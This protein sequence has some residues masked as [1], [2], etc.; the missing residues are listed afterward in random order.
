MT[1]LAKDIGNLEYSQLA[2]ISEA[3][4]IDLDDLLK[5]VTQNADGTFDASNLLDTLDFDKS[6]QEYINSI[7]AYND[8]VIAKQNEVTDN[9]KDEIQNIGNAKPG[10]SVNLTQL[11][12]EF[13][14]KTLNAINKKLK[15]YSASIEDGILKTS[16]NTNMASVISVLKDAGNFGEEIGQILRD[17][18]NEIIANYTDTINKGIKGSLTNV[19]AVNLQNFASNYGLQI[20]FHQTE[21][22][23]KLSQQSAMALYTTMKQVDYLQSR[24]VFKELSDNLKESTRSYQDVVAIQGRIADLQ[25][26]INSLP[27]GS[28]RRKEYERELEVAK[29]IREV[30]SLTDENA[31]NFM[32]ND[33]PTPFK[34]QLGY[35]DSIG[36]AFKEMNDAADSGYMDVTKFYN[37]V[38]GFN[39]MAKQMGTSINFMGME[40]DGSM[41]SASKA[42][43]KGFSSLANVDGEG[44]KVSLERWGNSFE[45]GAK[46]MQKGVQAG[47][48]AIA[49][50]QIEMLDAMIA[51]LELVVAME[52]LE[53]V[54]KN[55][56]NEISFEE[57]WPHFV[58]GEANQLSKE[59]KISLQNILDLA[60]KNKDLA[61]AL[62]TFQIEG[63]SM[64]YWMQQAIDGNIKNKDTAQ[65]FQ[66]TLSALY[67]ALQTG[68][69]S[70]ETIK[71]TIIQ[72]LQANIKEGEWREFTLTDGTKV[73]ISQKGYIEQ[74]KKGKWRVSGDGKE[75]DSFE[76][77]QNAAEKLTEFAEKT[78]I[79]DGH[80]NEAGLAEKSYKISE[81]T[82][83]TVTQNVNGEIEY[84][85]SKTGT[86]TTKAKTLRGAVR[87]IISR[88][89]GKDHLNADH[90]VQEADIL[91]LDLVSKLGLTVNDVEILT[92]QNVGNLSDKMLTALGIDTSLV[93][94]IEAGIERAL[95][96]INLGELILNGLLGESKDVDQMAIKSEADAEAVKKKLENN[97]KLKT[98]GYQ[99]ASGA[100]LAIKDGITENKELNIADIILDGL[101][102]PATVSEDGTS[103]WQTNDKVVELGR[104]LGIGIFQAIPGGVQAGNE[105]NP[106][107]IPDAVAAGAQDSNGIVGEAGQKLADFIKTP[108]QALGVNGTDS[109]T[110]AGMDAAQAFVDGFT[111]MYGQGDNRTSVFGEVF[112]A[113]IMDALRQALI[114]DETRAIGQETVGTLIE[115]MTASDG[116]SSS[117]VQQLADSITGPIKT[118]LT[119]LFS[120]TTLDDLIDL[121]KTNSDLVLAFDSIDIS[122]LTETV[123]TFET[124]MATANTALSGII[125]TINGL[126][127]TGPLYAAAFTL[128]VNNVSDKTPGYAAD[129][130]TA[131]NAVDQEKV[132]QSQNF[133]N[134]VN[135]VETE[136][137]DLSKAFVAAIASIEKEQITRAE[138][139]SAAINAI[140]ETGKKYAVEFAGAMN[141]ITSNG[142]DKI[143]DFKSAI[144]DFG[145]INAKASVEINVWGTGWVLNSSWDR[146]LA[147]GNIALGKGSLNNAPA[148]SKGRKTLMGELGPELYV[149]NGRYYVAGQNGAEMVD[150]PDDAIVFNHL[151]TKR[152]LGTG[153]AGRGKP[154][155]NEKRAI[156][157][158]TGNASGP[159]MA[160]ARE[161]LEQLKAL[162][163]MFRSMLTASFKQL[164]GLAASN[165]NKGGT[166]DKAVKTKDENGNETTT[167]I[168]ISRVTDDINRWYNLMR[169]IDKLEKD[170]SYSEQ[171]INKYQSDRV[172]NGNKIYQNYKNQLKMLDSEISK[173]KELVQIQRDWY[174]NKREEIAN[175]SYGLIFQYDENGLLQFVEGENRG[176][177]LLEKLNEETI[178]GEGIRYSSNAERQL[179][180][181]KQVGVD[182]NALAYD[183]SD[184][185]RNLQVY[186]YNTIYDRDKGEYLSEQELADWQA[187]VVQNFFDTAN[188]LQEEAKSLY[189]AMHETEEKILDEQIKQNEILQE[190]TNNQLEVEDIVLNAIIDA[191]EA[192]IDELQKERDAYQDSV[193]RMIS[194]L[195]DALDNEQKMYEDNENRSELTKLQRQLAILQRSGGSASQIRDLQN[196]ITSQQKDLYFDERQKEIQAIQDASDKQIERMDAQIDLMNDTLEYQKEHGL[197]WAQVYGI[198]SKTE[199]DILGFITENGADWEAKSSLQK[200]EDIRAILEKIQIWTQSRDDKELQEL[201][202]KIDNQEATTANRSESSFNSGNTVTVTASTSGSSSSSSKSSSNSKSTINSNTTRNNLKTTKAT[203]TTPSTPS[204][205]TARL[206]EGSTM[207]Y[208]QKSNGNFKEAEKRIGHSGDSIEVISSNVGYYGSKPVSLIEYNGK[209]YYIRSE[210]IAY[211]QG[212]LIDFT[213]PAWVDGSKSEPEA[214][215]SAQQTKMAQSFF[216]SFDE[217]TINALDDLVELKEKFGDL[218]NN[219]TS[220]RETR[221]QLMASKANMRLM[222]NLKELNNLRNSVDNLYDN[223]N[224]LD[225]NNMG[226]TIENVVLNMNVSKIANDYDAA[227]AGQK[228]LD[229]FV[230]V[231][232]KNGVNSLSR[233]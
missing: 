159:A 68:D 144:S 81:N 156:S 88:E 130:T 183:D 137:V 150:L 208:T 94:A 162:R 69:W 29:E 7:K 50:S 230:R 167:I 118:A 177:D 83:V 58:E 86:G 52:E 72:N 3:F 65:I 35:W 212:G 21:Q 161:T 108:L 24:V 39:D 189:D 158:A 228:V 218:F 179:A 89:F 40:L 134:A 201:G 121:F 231:A 62:D 217:H 16:A 112:G 4:K 192:E 216:N 49:K 45:D 117:K 95:S 57:L 166:K 232:R 38:N 128:A 148:L 180:L 28:A 188:A 20:D 219:N 214:I 132:T 191:R 168:K 186:D 233:R 48:R 198:M 197:L 26:Q 185:N 224:N 195:N 34:A 106:D 205:R 225:T 11:T 46:G 213:G 111:M 93:G 66:A 78:G 125:E 54:D 23:L 30:R 138:K 87:A 227:R 67:T 196:Q 184:A 77:A 19:D 27:V 146:S 113:Q 15:Q 43:Q 6:S 36:S 129:F 103:K 136:K 126:E 175:S 160:S 149:T 44:A 91:N 206:N 60:E 174:N 164:G 102:G 1:S 5:M 190:I 71:S 122:G 176:L 165:K 10:D 172:A 145:R 18:Y 153:R 215:L 114:T 142:V 116:K 31:F 41:E 181:L 8:S 178:Y 222:Q 127:A 171:L 204:Y 210:R 151:Q 104:Q 139:F 115:G 141:S 74:D 96:N 37:M 2:Q 107:A 63:K 64:R 70:P 157:Y 17:T 133:I 92:G 99:I 100:L 42:I 152:L 131:V 51:Q 120:Q 12:A 221:A 101:L 109:L 163:E 14:N 170:I 135:S 207:T 53:P 32:N 85:V 59:A 79:T 220:A 110:I 80:I 202:V 140:E 9:I 22:G 154:V 203:P 193:D 25:K 55:E 84:V 76:A 194:G 98:L 226:I 90:T 143:G 82:K 47:V 75:Y 169:Q 61:N 97:P 105:E 119:D 123:A 155:T 73:R 199:S 209:R 13:D 223:S 187:K 124:A 182:I 229:E 33:L 147:K 56:D 211:K 200:Q 173:N